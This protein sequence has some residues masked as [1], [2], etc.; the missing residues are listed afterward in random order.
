MTDD[1]SD[2]L[3]SCRAVLGWA[4]PGVTNISNMEKIRKLECDDILNLKRNVQSTM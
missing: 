1:S 4:T 2:L 3:M